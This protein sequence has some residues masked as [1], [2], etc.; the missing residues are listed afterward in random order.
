MTS[1]GEPVTSVEGLKTAD[2]VDSM[3][4]MHRHRCHILDLISPTPGRVLFGPAVTV[5]YFPSCSAALDP[6]RYN[7]ANL[8]HEAIGDEPEGKVLVL[9]SNGYT[10]TSMGGGT[11]LSRL[12]DDRC[13]GVLTD[14]RLRDF[15]E[16]A[17]YDFAAYCSGQAT[18]WGGGEVT[19]FQANVPVVVSRVG[20]TPGDYVFA[21]SSGAVV[22]PAGQ[23]DDVVAGARE[24]EDEDARSREEIDQEELRG[25][26]R[27]S[28]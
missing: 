11:K 18:R 6:D 8:F 21:D 12:Q 26:P 15:D 2:L 13:A 5:S 28:Q 16:L 3:G 23:V 4:R 17:G 10:E 25:E 22:I 9:A 27:N 24:V 7:L 19:P 1:Y 20:V 14:G